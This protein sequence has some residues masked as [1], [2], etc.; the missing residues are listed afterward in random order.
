[1]ATP[2]RSPEVL[3]RRNGPCSGCPDR[4]VKGEHYIVKV[5][6]KGWMHA[7][8]ADAYISARETFEELNREGGE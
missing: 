4:I 6:G 1:M 3:A 5:E 7:R 2:T 8:C